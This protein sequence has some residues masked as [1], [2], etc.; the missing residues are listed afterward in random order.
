MRRRGRVSLLDTNVVLRYLLGDDPVQSAHSTTLMKRLQQSKE[1]CEIVDV[2]IAE[3]IWVLQRKALVPRSDIAR[4]LAAVIQFSGVFYAGKRIALE[5]LTM[6]A[7][8]NCDIADCLLAARARSR[9]ISVR[10][11]DED[12]DKLG[13][14]REAP[15][16]DRSST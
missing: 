14:R 3:A 8:S 4:S 15:G 5:A 11:F 16:S 9:N 13:C 2:V 12:L 10:S 1:H 6:Y 7:D